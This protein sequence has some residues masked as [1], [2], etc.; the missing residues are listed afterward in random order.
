MKIPF[1]FI[2][3]PDF[4]SIKQKKEIYGTYKR[5]DTNSTVSP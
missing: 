4:C 3:F 2:D 5:T 1:G